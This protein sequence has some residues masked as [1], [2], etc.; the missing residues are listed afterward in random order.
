MRFRLVPRDQNLAAVKKLSGRGASALVTK[1]S[2][3]K[4]GAG[5]V[6]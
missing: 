5:L 1:L 3:Y 6:Y 2:V 4:E